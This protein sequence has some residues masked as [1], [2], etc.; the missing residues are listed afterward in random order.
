MRV[1]SVIQYP[2]AFD[3]GGQFYRRNILCEYRR[4]GKLLFQHFRGHVCHVDD[5]CRLR[6]DD[7]PSRFD[8]PVPF[9]DDEDSLRPPSA[10]RLRRVGVLRVFC[11]R[12]VDDL[13]GVRIHE[14]RLI[15]REPC[16]SEDVLRV[17]EVRLPERRIRHDGERRRVA[18]GDVAVHQVALIHEV[19]ADPAEA[20]RYAVR[21]CVTDVPLIRFLRNYPLENV[22]IYCCA[23]GIGRFFRKDRDVSEIL[24]LEARYDLHRL[25]DA[26]EDDH[27]ALLHLALFALRPL[28]SELE[29]K[30]L[31]KSLERGPPFSRRVLKFL[32]D[33]AG[34]LFHRVNGGGSLWLCL[35]FSYHNVIQLPASADFSVNGS[36]GLERPVFGRL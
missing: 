1:V 28:I 21:K 34:S 23:V 31:F 15:L 17:G 32:D 5:F 20:A 12:L 25:Q 13:G 18:D 14:L 19:D 9:F 30:I 35:F 16:V 11:L 36:N 7:R 3:D 8:G 33:D 24:A 4:V 2:A 26:V 10:R 27:R 22:R 29:L 6:I